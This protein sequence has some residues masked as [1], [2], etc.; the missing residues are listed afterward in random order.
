MGKHCRA[1]GWEDLFDLKQLFGVSVQA[2]T[3]RC[4]D[5]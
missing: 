1:I 5:L 2:L 4:K 3:Y